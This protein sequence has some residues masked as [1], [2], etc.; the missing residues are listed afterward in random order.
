[1]IRCTAVCQ[2]DISKSNGR[3]GMTIVNEDIIEFH[4]WVRFS[5]PN[6]LIDC[7]GQLTSVDEAIFMQYAESLEDP[8]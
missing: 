2:L 8:F 5:I 7:A 1:M 6:E 3:I 4:V